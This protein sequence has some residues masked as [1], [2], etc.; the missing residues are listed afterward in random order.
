VYVR[1]AEGALIPGAGPKLAAALG[2]GAAVDH[3]ERRSGLGQRGI[4]LA[5]VDR[6]K[7]RFH[8]VEPRGVSLTGSAEV[9][10]GFVPR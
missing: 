6:R 7:G 10:L 9:P 1:Y 5:R 2:I 3:R 8:L 4:V